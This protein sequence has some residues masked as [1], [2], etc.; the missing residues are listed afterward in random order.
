MEKIILDNRY[1]IIEQ[2]GIGGMAKVYKAK[3]RLLDRFVAIKVLKEQY[4]EDEEFLK[5]FNN[6]A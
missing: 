6:E 1:E 5:K 4:A 3:D 2:I